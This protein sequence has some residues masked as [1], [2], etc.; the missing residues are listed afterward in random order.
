MVAG[1]L[2]G[3]AFAGPLLPVLLVELFPAVAGPVAPVLPDWVMPVVLASP[4]LALGGRVRRGVYRAG[5]ATVARVTRD[6]DRVGGGTAG[7]G[8]TGRTGVPRGGAHR[9][10]RG[11]QVLLAPCAVALTVAIV[12]ALA[13]ALVQS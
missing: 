3:L 9:E 2:F 13:V 5:L 7:V 12:L 1:P 10:G 6:G 8:R 4:D 11:I